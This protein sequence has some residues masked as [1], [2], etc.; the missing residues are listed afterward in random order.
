M[1][2][3]TDETRR[4]GVGELWTG[5]P[6]VMAERDRRFNDA[7]LLRKV[8]D[9]CAA[10]HSSEFAVEVATHDAANVIFAED[11]GVEQPRRA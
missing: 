6:S 4:E 1:R 11:G 5:L 7:G 8:C 2:A 10:E 9:V 3:C